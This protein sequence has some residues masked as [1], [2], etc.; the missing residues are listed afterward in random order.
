MSDTDPAAEPIDEPTNETP[1][2]EAR[3]TDSP[4]PRQPVTGEDLID[5]VAQRRDTINYRASS[6]DQGRHEELTWVLDLIDPEVN[7]QPTAQ[8][9]TVEDEPDDGSDVS[10]AEVSDDEVTDEEPF[11]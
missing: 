1:D 3:D 9:N 10:D 8:T 6:Y 7:R 2:A 5:A 11:S 4:E